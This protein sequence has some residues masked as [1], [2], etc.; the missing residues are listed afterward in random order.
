MKKLKNKFIL[1]PLKLGYSE[2]GFVN[3]RHLK[4]YSERSHHIGAITLEPLYMDAGLRE[5]PSQ[6][7]IDNDDKIPGLSRLVSILHENGAK[8]IAHLNHPGRLA[9]PKIPGNYFWSS[10]EEAC[11]NGGAKPEM[12]DLSM[13][14][15]VKD[16]FVESAQR[17]VSCGFD[18]IELQFGHGYLLAQFLSPAVNKRTD[19]YN[20]SLQNRASFPLE[21]LRAVR[22]AVDVPIIARISGDEM[23]PEGLHL[24]EMIQF[25]LLL[26]QNGISAIHVSAGSACSTPPWFFQH[27]FVAKGKTWELAAKIKSE[28]KVPVIFVGQI[29]TREDIDLLEQKYNADYIAIGRAMVADPDFIAK[30]YG[31]K[32]GNIRPCLACSEGCLGNVRSGKGLGCV[33]NPLVNNT[34]PPLVKKE[35]T[36]K[37]AVIGGGLAGMQ[38]AITLKHRGFDVTIFEKEKLGG[39]FNLA[40]LPP[41]KES[42]KKI[43]DYFVEEINDLK[44][45]VIYKEATAEDITKGGFSQAIIAT[46]AKPFIPPVKGLKEYYWTEF[47]NN[48]QLPENKK[49]LI[50]GGGLIALEMASKL[51]DAKN[52]VIIIEM[53]DDIGR[54]M[55]MLERS[56]TINKLLKNG[57]QVYT[58]HK[59]SEVNQREVIIED[60]NNNKTIIGEVDKIIV[61]AGMKSY[62]PFHL[63]SQMQVHY[64]GDAKSVGKAENA[65][66]DAYKLALSL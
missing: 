29:N 61:A 30:Y 31:F 19:S 35:N 36:E 21:V 39:Q 6:L 20:G 12:M 34:L 32:S 25:S 41:N 10:T 45:P 63:E 56:Q 8:V 59:V 58:K 44:I 26:E 40:Y 57:V 51:I 22:K 11:E 46:G 48:D 1:A 17:A 37:I 54:G 66:H 15:R 9:N 55:E 49:V 14:N 2:G 16:L 24:D 47:L 33:V 65:I 52:H 28:V 27:M 50:I 4:F 23:I 43:I 64:I 18:F 62:V 53:L 7:G 5:I 42:L 3:E 60:E 38:A 13:M